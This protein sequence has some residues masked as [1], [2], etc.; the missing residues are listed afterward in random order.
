MLG[1]KGLLKLFFLDGSGIDMFKRLLSFLLVLLTVSFSGLTVRTEAKQD[2]W[3]YS[4]KDG[5]LMA[6]SEAVKEGEKST[7]YSN[8]ILSD[9]HEQRPLR[10][11]GKSKSS[12]INLNSYGL[13]KC[14]RGPNNYFY[15]EFVSQDALLAGIKQLG[16]DP[17][18]IFIQQD[19][20][21]KAENFSKGHEYMSWGSKALQIDEFLNYLSKTNNHSSA[22]V[23]IV[24]SGVATIEA[25]DDRMVQGYDFVDNDEDTSNDT[26]PQS[27]GTFLASIIADCTQETNISIMPIRVL[28]S[29]T[30]S[31]I[32][33]VNGII[34]AVDHGADVINFSIGGVL[35]DCAALDDAVTYAQEKG[36]LVVVSAG[37]EK[38]EIKDY[39]PAH[40]ESVITVSAVNEDL[41]FAEQFSNFGDA[42]DVAAPGVDIVG[43][44]AKSKKTTLTGTSMSA[45][46]ISACAALIKVSNPE[47]S[48]GDIRRTL[49]ESC[50]DLGNIGKDSLYGFGIPQM[51]RIAN[52]SYEDFL[53]SGILEVVTP[54]TNTV[55]AY[56]SEEG[57][58]PVGLCLQVCYNNDIVELVEDMSLVQFS[59]VDTSS[60]GKKIVLAKY[61]IY[62]TKIE[63]EVKYA[64]WQW[65]I[66]ILLF[67]WIWY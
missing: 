14:M 55:Y 43:Y 56:R 4:S 17:N 22:T 8:S 40:N 66:L 13:I 42:I 1:G 67:G 65:I 12:S 39:C 34:Y 2:V 31:L 9:Q 5:F 25:L 20:W 18:I 29:R 61:K 23:A 35:P 63:I 51:E 28:S 54:P 57:F 49:K 58:D 30:G 6:V 27:H 32:N 48:A 44:N 36:V 46:F 33:A 45:A 59:W 26:H 38:M 41:T 10:I 11:I 19:C 15:M 64:W 7:L 16:N 50:M 3:V 60:V 37:N 21:I 24:D 47:Y 52:N 53:Q 62:E